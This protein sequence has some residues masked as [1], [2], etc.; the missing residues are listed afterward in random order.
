M[1]GLTP[2]WNGPGIQ[3]QERNIVEMRVPREARDGPI[4]GRSLVPAAQAHS[5]EYKQAARSR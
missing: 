5:G 3:R 1:S 4:P 2:R